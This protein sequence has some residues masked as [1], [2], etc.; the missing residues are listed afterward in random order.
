MTSGWKSFWQHYKLQV[1]DV[2]VFQM[3]QHTPPSFKVTIFPAREQHQELQAK[4]SSLNQGVVADM[5]TEEELE[6]ESCE[7]LEGIKLEGTT[8][9]THIDYTYTN[10][11]LRSMSPERQ[12]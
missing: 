12:L 2:C 5:A 10:T 9:N 3:T 8:I 4:L 1:N 6:T 11:K 7:G